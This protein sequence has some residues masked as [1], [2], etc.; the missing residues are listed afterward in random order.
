MDTTIL[1]ITGAIILGMFLAWLFGY[2]PLPKD[3]GR[4]KNKKREQ[5]LF[6]VLLKDMKENPGHWVQN[7]FSP[8]MLASPMLINDKKNI[9]IQYG[10][11]ETSLS[12]QF[13]MKDV[14]K[15]SRTDSDAIITT[16][17][18]RHVTK[19]LKAAIHLLDHRGKELEYFTEKLKEKL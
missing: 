18:G 9:G 3:P 10:E 19:F 15:F 5:R 8:Q 17:T 12:I 4:H 6:Q 11:K 14:V 13:N 16:I 7:G 2:K 1:L